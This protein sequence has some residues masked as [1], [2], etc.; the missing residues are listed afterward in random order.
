LFAPF[1]PFTSERLNGFFGYESPLFGQAYTE[2]V[3]DAR[4]VCTQRLSY[5][6]R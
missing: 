1:L 2:T 3:T 4:A 6:K 5:G